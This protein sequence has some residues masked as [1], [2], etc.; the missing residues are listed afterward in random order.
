M[1]GCRGRAVINPALFC[2]VTFF[3]WPPNVAK[4]M[5]ATS[6]QSSASCNLFDSLGWD[7]IHKTCI[8]AAGI[9][10]VALHIETYHDNELAL[11]S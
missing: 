9:A 3:S 1:K 8:M 5:L 7:D 4:T 6:P 11:A 10:H 2:T